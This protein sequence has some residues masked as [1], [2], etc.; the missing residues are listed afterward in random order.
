MVQCSHKLKVSPGQVGV[1]EVRSL[2]LSFQE[3]G[4]T[5][6]EYNAHDQVSMQQL[7][8]QFARKVRFDG[9]IGMFLSSSFKHL[10]TLFM[11]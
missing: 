1:W 7:D 6:L 5:I 9:A 10:Q 2:P 3:P 11:Q 8:I 4:Q